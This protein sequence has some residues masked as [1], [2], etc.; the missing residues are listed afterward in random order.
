MKELIGKVAL[1]AGST[2]GIGKAVAMKLA[3]MGADIVLLA[4][5]KRS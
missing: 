4:A 5:T 1:V 3:E 2:Q